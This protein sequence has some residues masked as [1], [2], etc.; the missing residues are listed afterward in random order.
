MEMYVETCACGTLHVR[1]WVGA[2]AMEVA[3]VMKTHLPCHV[4]IAPA[5]KLEKSATK[6]VSGTKPA[7][8]TVVVMD[9]GAV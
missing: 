8:G 4:T 3:T 2:W 6:S 9:K 1:R 5:R 7:V